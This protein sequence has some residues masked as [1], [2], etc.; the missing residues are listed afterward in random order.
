M[1]WKIESSHV[2]GFKA[3]MGHFPEGEGVDACRDQPSRLSGDAEPT[4]DKNRRRVRVK[5]E[6]RKGGRGLKR[7]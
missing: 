3:G 1:F 6:R 5:T 7:S 4:L 2:Q